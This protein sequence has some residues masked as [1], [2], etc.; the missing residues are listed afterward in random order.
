MYS[1]IIRRIN[2]QKLEDNLLR[3]DTRDDESF[4]QSEIR[5][6]TEIV[7]KLGS[8][9]SQDVSLVAN[10]LL[11]LA[12]AT[13]RSC[14]DQRPQLN[15]YVR[16]TR[17]SEYRLERSCEWSGKYGGISQSK[18]YSVDNTTLKSKSEDD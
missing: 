2:Y 1:D 8:L 18:P 6:A 17:L 14:Q 15:F 12:D 16:M 4:D 3:S 5:I 11:G 7:E 13:I 9:L 10:V